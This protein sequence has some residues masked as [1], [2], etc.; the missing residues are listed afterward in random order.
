MLTPPWRSSLEDA[1]LWI[2]GWR[3]TMAFHLL[4]SKSGLQLEARLGNAEF[5]NF[6]L[7]LRIDSL[8]KDTIREEE[9][10]TEKMVKQQEMVADSM[11]ELSHVLS[12]LMRKRSSEDAAARLEEQER[13]L[14]VESALEPKEEVIDILS[15]IQAVHFLIAAAELHLRIHE[16]G[17]RRD[18]RQS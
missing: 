6:D 4:H 17:K 1:F 3:P 11:V 13:Q 15:P 8:Q 7:D 10:I 18:A 12:E 9:E 5:Y 14:S 2:G 16:L